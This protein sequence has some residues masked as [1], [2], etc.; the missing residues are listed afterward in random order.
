M[1]RLRGR[2]VAWG[3][4]TVALEHGRLT[5]TFKLGPRTAAEAAILV[6]ARLGRQLAVTS[7]LR[8]D[9]SSHVEPKP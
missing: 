4:K 3:A 7:M 9:L 8:R 5:V 6:S 2:N 1:G